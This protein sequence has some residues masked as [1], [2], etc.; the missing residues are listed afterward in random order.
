MEKETIMFLDAMHQGLTISD[1]DGKLLYINDSAAEYFG[2][3]KNEAVGQSADYLE[4]TGKFTPSITKMVMEQNKTVKA[5]QKDVNGNELLGTGIPVCDNGKLKYIVCF[6]AWDLFTPD[7]LKERYEE[8][9]AVNSRLSKELED[10]RKNNQIKYDIVAESK[11]MQDNIRLVTKIADTKTPVYIWGAEG[12]GKRSMAKEI[13]KI[14][15]WHNEP[16]EIINCSLFSDEIIDATLFGDDKQMGLADIV[17][18]GTI[19]VENIENMSGYIQSKLRIYMREKTARFIITSKFPLEELHR[20]NKVISDLYYALSVIKVEMPPI[21]ERIEDLKKYINIYLDEFNKKYERNISLMP[22]AY[23]ALLSYK[24]P[25]NISQ[26]K[27]IMERIV[28]MADSEKV[29]VY[30]LPK[31]ITSFSK[32]NFKDRFSLKEEM[33]SFEKELIIHAYDR[34]KTTVAVAEALGI[35][36]ASAVRRLQK[37]IVG[38]GK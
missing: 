7:D 14:S 19:I 36:Q 4:Q 38:Y 32:E 2:I 11:I 26:V 8:V 27:A 9:K 35:S 6:S 24:W 29:N 17:G 1:R 18:N 15:K 12:C 31:E 21:N 23:S 34:Y 16:M 28:L 37:Y 13:H 30:D 20:E 10:L 25:D 3:D 33:E 5:I 22:K